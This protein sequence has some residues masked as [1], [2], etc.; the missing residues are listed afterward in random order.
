MHG[1][2]LES[3]QYISNDINKE[4]GNTINRPA[5]RHHHIRLR[6]NRIKDLS[7]REHAYSTGN[8]KETPRFPVLLSQ[9]K[10]IIQV[11]KR[12]GAL[13]KLFSKFSQY[14]YY[15]CEIK[16]ARLCTSTFKIFG[17][18]ATSL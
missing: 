15:N 7:K 14:P 2:S 4:L 8:V 5:C 10:A 3:M 18:V 17:L 12:G 9:T 16:L 1:K 11:Q 6:Q 13:T